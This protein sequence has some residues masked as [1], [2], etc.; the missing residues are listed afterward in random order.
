MRGPATLPTSGARFQVTYRLTPPGGREEDARALANA[1]CVEQTVEFPADL[2]PPGPIP[3]E[4]VARLVDLAPAAPSSPAA[5][6]SAAP[7]TADGAFDAT[8]DFAVETAGAELT[9]L[10]NVLFGNAS[11]LPGVRVQELALPPEVLAPYPG[12]RFGRAGLRRLLG[13]PARP[14]VATALKPMGLD[15]PALARLAYQL[16]Q[17]G[18]DLIKDDH[19]LADQPFAPFA[20]RVEACA[21]AVARANAETGG[22]TLYAPNVSAP[23]DAMGARARFARD[24]GAGAL[25]AAAGLVGF[26]TL[27]ALAADDSLG[28]PLLGHPAWLGSHALSPTHGVAHGVLFGALHR[29][30]GADAVIFPNFGGRF[31]FAPGACAEIRQATARPLGTLA[32]IFPAPAGGMTLARVPELV[33]FYGPDVMLLIGGNLHRHPHGVGAACRALVQ[34]AEHA[35]R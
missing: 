22:H 35:A 12:P 24:A 34:A 20:A 26:D 9:Q 30:A 21:A 4:V 10:L 19:G 13:V 33:A 6:P 3:E 16:A 17:G 18:V 14:L 32:P 1:L 5:A 31:S 25:M 27:R 2:L 29:L 8:L 11:L 15:V 7:T 28:L 23:A